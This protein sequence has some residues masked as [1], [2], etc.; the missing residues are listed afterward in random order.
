MVGATR[1]PGHRRLPAGSVIAVAM[2]V[3]SIAT[4]GFTMI[5][6]R[7][8]GPGSYGALVAMMNTLLVVSVLQLGLQATAARR[9]ADTPEHV[10]QI[11]A[12]IL[13][14]T[15]RAALLLGLVMLLLAPLI[16]R[17]LRLDSLTT[18]VVMALTAVPMTLMGGQAGILQGER[19]WA[20]LA[21]LYLANGVPRLVIGCALMAWRPDELTAIVG[22]ALGQVAPV[23][24]GWWALRDRRHPALHHEDHRIGALVRETLHNS[25]A[26]L[27]F[28]T[29]SNV[30]VVVARN[31]LPEHQAGLYAGGLILTKA[32]LFL[33]QFVV[34]VAFPTMSTAAERRRA[35]TRSLAAVALLGLGATLGA[36]LLPGI[37][38]VFVGG[39]EYA[40]IESR[41]WLFAVLGTLLS[42]L[43]LLVYAV[44][45]R[46]G[47]RSVVLVWAALAT[48]VAAGLVTSGVTQLLLVVVAVD[49]LLFVALLGISLVLV[50]HP[51]PEST[52][53]VA[54]AP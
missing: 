3:M 48:L 50:R 6:A 38:M 42:M 19:R 27:A 12:T 39:P 26:L 49:V 25:Q 47:R 10:A 22:V 34:V 43:Q 15:L 52:P 9:I 20:A 16:D 53:V 35:L 51:A 11:E 37:A 41:L 8:L 29:L 4:Y 33:P 5:A 18:A 54:A 36:L 44:I 13:R 45:A 31:V 46:Q 2:A 7:I 40:E 30:D 23:L 1:E 17:V 21:V 32:V 28:F 14:V 24:V